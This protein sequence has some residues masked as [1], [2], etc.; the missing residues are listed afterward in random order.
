MLEPIPAVMG[1]RQGTPWMGHQSTRTHRE[2]DNNTHSHLH[3]KAKLKSL[4][5]HQ[6]TSS[7]SLGGSQSTRRKPTPT[8]REHANSAQ[9]GPTWDQTQVL[10]TVKREWWP[11]HHH[12]ALKWAPFALKIFESGRDLQLIGWSFSPLRLICFNI[13]IQWR[14]FWPTKWGVAVAH[15]VL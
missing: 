15:S 1:R 3:L 14:Q 13:Q 10:L 6:F 5:S 12:V 11:L 9:R 7:L 8:W 2:T 4:V